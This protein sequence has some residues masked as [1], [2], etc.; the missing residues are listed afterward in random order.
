MMK[1]SLIVLLFLIA[2]S[3]LFAQQNE[4]Q[5]II[6]QGWNF[7]ALPAITFDSDLG[8]QYGAVVNLF[9]YGDGSRY[10]EYN[11]SLYF[12]AS[13]FTKGSSIYRFQYDS[14]R[15]LKGL[16][17]F[18]DLSYLTDQLYSFYGFNGYDAIYQKNWVD[19][20]SADYISRGFYA[21]DR[22]LFRFKFDLQGPVKTEKLRWMAGVNFQVFKVGSLQLDKLNKGKKEDKK[23]PDVDGLYEKY[24]QWGLINSE[25]ADGGTITS[26]K[27]GLTYDTRD[28]RSIPERGVWSEIILEFVPEILGTESSFTRLSLTHRQYFRML[29]KKLTFA[30]RLS[31]QAKLSGNVPFYYLTQLGATGAKGTCI[32]GLGGSKSVRGV[33]RNRVIGDD[34]AFGNLELRWRITEF[35]YKQNNFFIG[36]NGF[37]DGGMVTGKR[38]LNFYPTYA[39]I[40]T[41]DYLKANAENLHL[42]YGSSLKVGMNENFVVSFDYGRAADKRDGTAGLYMGLNYLF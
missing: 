38:S 10:P 16:Q 3:E 28:F 20:E 29:P 37:I 36:L 30:Y 7:G 42:A 35:Q 19:D 23:L 9:H 8:F 24:V 13:R 39:A 5:E 15:L 22:K 2:F 26:F 40:D 25:E 33:L 32:E 11:H 6:K 27:A 21:Y 14:D 1:P 31:Y 34:M 18:A 4:K 17:T 41:S 12:E